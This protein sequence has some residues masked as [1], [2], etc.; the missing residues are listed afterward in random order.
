MRA[1]YTLGA[2][3]IITVAA[4]ASA[5]SPLPKEGAGSTTTY[6][7][8]T[9]KIMRLGDDVGQT[10]RRVADREFARFPGPHAVI[11]ARVESTR[12]GRPPVDGRPGTQRG[13][14]VLGRVEGSPGSRDLEYQ[15]VKDCS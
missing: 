5:Q 7:T 10:G 2:V 9:L 12:S 11:P 4:T 1:Y 8:S 15:T 3:A 6:F 14:Q 13:A